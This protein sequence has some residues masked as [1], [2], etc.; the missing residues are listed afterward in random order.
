M[1]TRVQSA[2]GLYSLRQGAL[3]DFCAHS[4]SRRRQRRRRKKRKKE[5]RRKRM[6]ERRKRSSS[7]SCLR[8]R[9]WLDT[10]DLEPE[11]IGGAGPRTALSG[12]THRWTQARESTN[13]Y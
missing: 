3:G 13:A 4:A 2:D 8:S 1:L 12:V 6:K 5:R 9:G 7:S 10:L 11:A